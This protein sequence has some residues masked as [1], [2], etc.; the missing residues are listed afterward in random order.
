[1]SKDL[2][3]DEK[4][5]D[6][7]DEL[8]KMEKELH[9][10]TGFVVKEEEWE[11]NVSIEPQQNQNE[12]EINKTVNNKQTLNQEKRFTCDVCDKKFARM[13]H[14][15]EH[16]LIHSKEKNYSCDRCGK[17][18]TRQS[19]L[20]RHN[21]QQ[22]AEEKSF[23]SN[24]K[25]EGWSNQYF[26]CDI[27]EKMFESEFNFETHKRCHTDETFSCDACEKKNNPT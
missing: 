4:T 5:L 23:S 21:R 2:S 22:H 8:I 17:K 18:F 11:E 9:P 26:S 27:C 19:S 16:N 20:N 3:F 10:E 6:I 13:S 14:L 12:N 15:L 1:M 24:I 25:D 7:S